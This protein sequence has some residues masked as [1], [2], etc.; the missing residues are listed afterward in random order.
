MLSAHFNLFLYNS[1]QDMGNIRK[2]NLFISRFINM[3]L[4]G[5]CKGPRCLDSVSHLISCK[6]T[7]KLQP[8][9]GPSFLSELPV[10]FG[11][12]CLPPCVCID[13]CCLPFSSFL[14]DLGG[15]HRQLVWQLTCVD[16]LY[17]L[18]LFACF[19]TKAYVSEQ[20]ELKL[21]MQLGTPSSSQTFL[22]LL[23]QSAEITGVWI[24]LDLHLCLYL[25]LCMKN[26]L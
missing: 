7:R 10:R 16:S 20:A 22:I 13:H 14:L 9:V 6:S 23:L 12:L 25:F 26:A 2:N 11:W 18:L 19:E 21:T 24:I 15:F 1:F 8:G 4:Q 17:F 5:F 3:K